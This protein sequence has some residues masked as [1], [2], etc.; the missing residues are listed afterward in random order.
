MNQGKFS[1]AVWFLIGLGA[2]ILLARAAISGGAGSAQGFIVQGKVV[3][4]DAK[5][6]APN[7][8]VVLR[9]QPLGKGDVILSTKTDDQGAFACP[10]PVDPAKGIYPMVQT[11]K[12]AKYMSKA[13]PNIKGSCTNCHGQSVKD[14]VAE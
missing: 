12:S 1:R 2:V 3:Q 14:I 8:T 13:V 5:T 10:D 11:D 7:V 9:S 6:P 4:A